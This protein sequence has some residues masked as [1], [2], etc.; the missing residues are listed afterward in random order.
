MVVIGFYG[1]VLTPLSCKGRERAA[2]LPQ[3][4]DR[5]PERKP[6]RRLSLKERGLVKCF[7]MGK[8]WRKRKPLISQSILSMGFSI[9]YAK[10]CKIS[11]LYRGIYGS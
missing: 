7:L 4:R 5:L 10:R 2:G 1:V 3:Y 8:P 6:T 9:G 11:T